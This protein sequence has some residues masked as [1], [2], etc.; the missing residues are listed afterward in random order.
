MFQDD[1]SSKLSIDKFA[2]KILSK[3]K[4]NA[5]FFHEIVQTNQYI[6]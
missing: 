4:I 5:E 3:S 1:A 2:W 6:Q